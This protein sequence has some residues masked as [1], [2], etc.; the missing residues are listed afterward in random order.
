M[1]IDGHAHALGEYADPDSIIEIMDK[2][3]V[4]KV[5]LCPGGA[6]NPFEYKKPKYKENFFITRPMLLMLSGRILRRMTR[7]TKTRD[8]GNIFVA[9]LVEKLPHR[10]I[11]FYWVDLSDPECFTL[12]KDSYKKW[13][14]KGI[15]LHQ[16]ANAFKIDS[17]E[18]NKLVEF[19]REMD[20]PIFIHLYSIREANKLVKLVRNNP[21]VNFTIAHLM[22]LENFIRKGKGLKNIYFDISPY[23]IISKRRIKKAIKHFGANR[24]LLGTDSPLG[25]DNLE[26]NIK[27]IQNMKISNEEKEMILG[28]NIANLLNL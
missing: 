1:I 26:N 28:E 20:L 5:V 22:G 18:M 6:N 25:I 16:G 2:F 3:H 9:K 19:T 12:L 10:I 8:E 11:Q 13:N 4:D 14:F 24:V 15:K 17:A 27:K 21:D 23:Y 7:G